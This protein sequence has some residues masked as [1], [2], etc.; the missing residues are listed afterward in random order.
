MEPEPKSPSLLPWE[1]KTAI[2][3]L[4]LLAAMELHAGFQFCQGKPRLGFSEPSWSFGVLLLLF[5]G[6]ALGIQKRL[7]L[8]EWM[9]IVAV[10]ALGGFM[11]DALGESIWE[12][13]TFRGRTR[14]VSSYKWYQSLR[15]L[16][17]GEAVQLASQCVLLAA[18]PPLLIL[19]GIRRSLL[20]P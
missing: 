4:V 12:S 19:G 2:G 7:A 15:R 17:P 20:K 18:V 16:E 14:S 10:G 6:L 9:A 8:A 1:H 3:C 5:A 13:L 11:V